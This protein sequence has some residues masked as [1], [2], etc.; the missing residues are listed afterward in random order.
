VTPLAP[1]RRECANVL[2]GAFRRAIPFRSHVTADGRRPGNQ[3]VKPEAA[4][5]NPVA[6]P[7]A[8]P[9]A[10]LATQEVTQDSIT[11]VLAIGFSL[12]IIVLLLGGSVEFRSIA[13]IQENAAYLVRQEHITTTLIE[14]L[15]DEQ[16]TLSEIFYTITGDPDTA[17]PGL[18]SQRL[19]QVQKNLRSMLDEAAPSGIE[20]AIWNDLLETSRAFGVE[21]RRLLGDRD[22]PEL[23]SRDLFRS[24][25]QVIYLISRLVAQGFDRISDTE[26]EIERRAVR[27]N[28]E[29]VTLIGTCL[30]LALVC[31]IVTARKT[32]QLFRAM[33]WQERELARVSWQMLEDQETIA[34]RFSHELHDE[35]GQTLAAL[36]ANLAAVPREPG[37]ISR[38]DDSTRLVDESIRNVRQLSQLLRPMILDDFGLDAG[39][40]WLCDGFMQRTGIEVVYQSNCRSRLPD[41]TET[42]L[43][44][45]AQEALTN[46]SRHSGAT[47][48]S[49][50][51]HSDDREIRLSVADNGKGILKGAATGP[52]L[53][54]TGMGMTGMRARARAV[55]GVFTVTS[56]EGRGVRIEARV[57]LPES[58]EEE[59]EPYSNLAR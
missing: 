31:S 46:V 26:Q 35:L 45:M 20:R 57:P 2:T 59:H 12:V 7:V 49:V 4:E 17:N 15:Q 23:G 55:G 8:Q 28:R 21:A 39:L 9:V 11:R 18:I 43:F 25:E 47:K 48:V 34:R 52:G 58:A 13:S 44:R 37:T 38:L 10:Q 16:K 56:P 14:S 27:F 24:H 42:H 54:L 40:S 50:D 32:N 19:D 5:Q 22:S 3:P 6:H 53:Q 33:N 1:S 36:K 29:S 41:E 51:L 30:L